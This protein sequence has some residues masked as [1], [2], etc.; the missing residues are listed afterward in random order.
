MGVL[1]EIDR[2][3]RGFH[4]E[5]DDELVRLQRTSV[6]PADYWR[7]LLRCYGWVAPVER[8]ILEVAGL[9]KSIDTARFHKRDLLRSDLVCFRMREMEIAGLPQ[10]A[11]PRFVSVEEAL[12]WAYPIERSTLAHANVYRH[13]A[14]H[15][16]GEIAFTSSYLKCYLGTSGQAWRGFATA[17]ERIADSPTGAQQLIG[18]ATAA[19]RALL[20]WR[21][22][23]S[24]LSSDSDGPRA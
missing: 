13:L 8:A 6:S 12:G 18:G 5:A 23:H 24:Q 22:H 2:V 1:G 21:R 20:D 10:Y 15:M 19:F 14:A 3:T 11:V 17:L 7:F 9:D 16:P 4:P